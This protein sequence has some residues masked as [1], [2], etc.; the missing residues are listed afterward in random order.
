MENKFFSNIFTVVKLTLNVAYH[1][2]HFASRVIAATW[3]LGRT[4]PMQKGSSRVGQFGKC[5]LF[6]SYSFAK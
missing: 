5:L 1:D 6:P 4:S 3:Q 2:L